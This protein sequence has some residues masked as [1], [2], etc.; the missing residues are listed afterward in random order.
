MAFT[1]LP[2]DYMR[3]SLKFTRTVYNDV[4]PALNPTKPELSL[5]GKVAI[6]TG[7]STGIGA[8]GFAPAFAKAGVRGLVLLA[9]NA[10]KL[11][12]VETR[13]TLINPDVKVLNLAVDIANSQSVDAAF[14]KIKA[15]FG[16]VDILVNNAGRNAAD[17]GA[18][19]DDADPEVWWSNFEINGKGT[20]LVTRCFIRQLPSTD[21]VATIINVTTA[22]AWSIIPQSSA[23]CLSKLVGLQLVPFI[24][25][26]YPNI[27]AVA[28]HPGM[29]ETA[30]LYD[31]MRHF[32]LD[33]PALSGAFGVWLCHPHA[34]FL[35]GRF[36]AAQWSVEEL[37]E[38]KEEIL[39]GRQLLLTVPG[40]FGPKQFQ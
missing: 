24:A 3:E 13:I 16:H 21:S 7:A 11:T 27:T 22:G 2:K 25:E 34:R 20:F 19:I 36:V 37:L 35:S 26:S 14:E 39:G 10:E 9:R 40:P 6:V 5:A 1:D 12:E 33:S 18:L 38:R 8:E 30:M 31:A 28:L 23:Y 17:N 4:Y 15:R 29:I 32:D